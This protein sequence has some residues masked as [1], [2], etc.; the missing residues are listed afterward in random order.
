M[1][2]E[3]V[4]NYNRALPL[5]QYIVIDAALNGNSLQYGSGIVM[6]ELVNYNAFIAYYERFQSII[7]SR[8]LQVPDI[9]KHMPFRGRGG[10]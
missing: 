4:S 1:H 3:I 9:R 8:G 7:M 10:Q 2:I 6:P 5:L